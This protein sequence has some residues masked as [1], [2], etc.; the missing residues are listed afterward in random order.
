M[1]GSTSAQRL[2]RMLALVPWLTAHDGVTIEEA[3]AHFEVSAEQLEKDLWLLIVCGL[4]GYGPDQLV[5]IDF[6]DDGRIHVIDAQTLDRPLRLNAEE[7]MSLLLGLR[8]LE[9]V[10][11]VHDRSAIISTAAKLSQAVDLP[12]EDAAV[13]GHPRLDE[14]MSAAVATAINLSAD[15][16]ITYASGTS[17]QVTE[18][19]ITPHQVVLADGRAYLEAFCFLAGAH[20]TFRMDR[21]LRVSAAPGLTL[22]PE[23][24]PAPA[25]THSEATALV[26]VE[27]GSAWIIDVLGAEVSGTTPDGRIAAR[28][29][30]ADPRWLVRLALSRGGQIE[31]L[32]P[33]SV[34]TDVTD[35]AA[36]A[37]RAYAGG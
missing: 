8:L 4:P 17:D 6:W 29:A 34:R 14:A 32:Q 35:A 36:A 18:R 37:L 7:A 10:P 33:E 3:A 16:A 9:Q 24:A 23:E 28:L 11:G 27:S 12:A 15:L 31:I 19:R 30:Y 25:P 26:A 1:S 2:S 5:D 20:R 13:S 22:E 21:I